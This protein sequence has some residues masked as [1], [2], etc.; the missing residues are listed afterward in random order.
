MR[1]QFVNYNDAYAT[2]LNKQMLL[3]LARLANGHPAYYLAIGEI[4]NRYTFSSQ[5]S[6]GINGSLQDSHTTTGNTPFVSGA[7]AGIAGFPLAVAQ[8]VF[9][10]IFGGSANESVTA[11]SSPEFLFIPINNEEAAKQVLQP[12]DPE[13]FLSLYQQGYPIDQLMRIMI[14][15]IDVPNLPNGDHFV[16]VNSPTTPDP[17]YYERFLRACAIL[18]TLQANGYLWLDAEPDLKLLGPVA[19]SSKA[20]G[21]GGKGQTP[22]EPAASDGNPNPSPADFVDAQNNN[23][24]LIYTNLPAHRHLADT[25]APDSSV[26]A[27]TNSTPKS[28]F[29]WMAYQKEAIPKFFLRYE[30]E[31]RPEQQKKIRELREQLEMNKDGH[32]LAEQKQALAQITALLLANATPLI[33]F[34]EITNAA[35][36]RNVTDNYDAITNVISALCEGVS[37]QTDVGQNDPTTT[38]L[39]LRSFNRT[40][41]SVANE[42]PAFEELLTKDGP[43]I[44]ETI[45]GFEQRPVLQM[46]WTNVPG[47]LQP[48]TETV[49]YVDKTYQ[50]TDVIMS[51]T[52]S[53]AT[54][55]R[56]TF[57]L[58]I[59]LSS[60]VTVDISKFQRQILELEQ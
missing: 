54:W 38:R 39:V 10:T 11:Q 25:N 36:F 48:P 59:G 18:R 17:A 44:R 28:E 30:Y 26:A 12:L 41:E 35:D 52:N 56:D 3:N 57:R 23:M 33:Q 19:F 6:A 2:S 13:V 8:K 45:P 34:L 47:S 50:I 32:T 1:S 49:S 21:G 20:G 40:M 4:D 60:Q 29:G 53:V 46:I 55:N 43:V 22:G 27:D 7:P 51:P 24:V 16:L 42:Q 9:Q 37:I 31:P 58:L 14:E 15:R 5:T